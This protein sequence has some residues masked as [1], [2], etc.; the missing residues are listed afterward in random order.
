MS[1]E[2]HKRVCGISTANPDGC[3]LSQ[4][5][6]INEP[7]TD[8]EKMI[9]QVWCDVLNLLPEKVGVTQDF[10]TLGGNSILAMVMASK[11]RK[12]GF[13]M[14]VSDLFMTRTITKFAARI[15]YTAKPQKDRNM[16]PLGLRLVNFA[17][18]SNLDNEIDT[19]YESE[20]SDATT[21]A[22]SLSIA[23][24]IYTKE[25]QPVSN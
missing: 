22:T 21:A 5:F 11:L 16:R 20:N 19:G 17:G 25:A 15:G 4:P 9:H 7:S 2:L 10:V 8:A 13:Q 24:H 6:Q 12:A 1:D 23:S 18:N 3:P 14:S